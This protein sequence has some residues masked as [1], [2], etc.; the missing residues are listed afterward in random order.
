MNYFSDNSRKAIQETGWS[1]DAIEVSS[2]CCPLLEAKARTY[3]CVFLVS[4]VSFCLMKSV[5]KMLGSKQY[6]Q[7]A[8]A[9]CYVFSP[10]CA[11]YRTK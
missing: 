4:C 9:S 3:G 11:L 10:S 5:M 6:H 8:A 2:A 7:L 1:F